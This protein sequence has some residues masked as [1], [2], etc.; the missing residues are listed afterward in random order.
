MDATGGEQLAKDLLHVNELFVLTH[1]QLYL[2]VHPVIW[3]FVIPVGT[4][5]IFLKHR[6]TVYGFYV[7]MIVPS[8]GLSMEIYLLL[9]GLLFL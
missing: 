8:I 3:V 9:F 7:S 1:I 6:N 4:L 2:T 5:F